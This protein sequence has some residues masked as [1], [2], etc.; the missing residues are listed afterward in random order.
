M[1]HLPLSNKGWLRQLRPNAKPKTIVRFEN[2][3]HHHQSGRADRLI[4]ARLAAFRDMGY[5]DAD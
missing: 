2:R 4:A 1:C 3:V 5:C